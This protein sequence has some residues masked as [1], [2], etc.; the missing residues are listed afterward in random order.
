M[1]DGGNVRCNEHNRLISASPTSACVIFQ[2]IFKRI[3]P[4]VKAHGV[5]LLCSI[6]TLDK[7]RVCGSTN[8]NE[9]FYVSQRGAAGGGRR[10]AAAF[11]WRELN[12]ASEK[13]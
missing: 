8:A 13:V 10:R 11:V 4:D 1:F 3:A 5:L 2:Q 12:R 7:Y 6:V 9:R